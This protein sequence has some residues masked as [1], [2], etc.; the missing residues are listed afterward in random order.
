MASFRLTK[1]VACILLSVFAGVAVLDGG[2]AYAARASRATTRAAAKDGAYRVRAGRAQL[3]LPAD[4]RVVGGKYDVI[5]HFHGMPRAQEANVTAAGINAAVVTINLGAV[6]S[7]YGKW[8]RSPKA[9]DRILAKTH[10]LVMQSGRAPRRARIGR[11]ALSAWSA[12]FGAVGA[13]MKHEKARA[14]VDAVLLADG[15]HAP[16]VDKKRRIIDESSLAKYARLSEEAARGEKLFVMTHSAIETHGYANVTE[17]V[18]TVL[19]LASLDLERQAP[20]PAAPRNMRPLYR[21]DKGDF[22]VIGFEGRTA[23]DHIDHIWAM[24]ETMF[25]LLAA[26]WQ[27]APRNSV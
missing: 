7:R 18:G 15:L 25:P 22:H 2:D 11:V 3:F 13:I 24:G 5:V 4:F 19:R 21:V 23:R 8:Y 16:Y 14:R 17:T 6:P 1:H 26:R 27:G 12:G 20:P 9:L 10:R